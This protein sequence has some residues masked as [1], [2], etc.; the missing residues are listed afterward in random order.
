MKTRTVIEY[1]IDVVRKAWGPDA[2]YNIVR[3]NRAFT[4]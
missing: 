3:E 1:I 2:S 4:F